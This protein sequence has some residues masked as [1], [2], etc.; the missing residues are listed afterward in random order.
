MWGSIIGAVTNT[1]GGYLKGK[2]AIAGAKLKG[3]LVEIEAEAKTKLAIAKG[4]IRMAEEG[5]MQNFNLDQIAMKNMEKSYKDELILIV[6]MTPMV[7]AFIPSMDIYALRGFEV[8]QQMPEWYQY[9]LI[10][11]VVV[12]YGMRGMLEKIIASKVPTFK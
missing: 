12:I 10:G 5:Q 8:I 4:K 11:M 9:T 2:Q 7:L 3:Q 1:V 6:F